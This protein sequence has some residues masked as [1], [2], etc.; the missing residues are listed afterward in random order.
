MMSFSEAIKTC[1]F[2]KIFVTSDTARRSEFWWFVLFCH[3]IE[4]CIFVGLIQVETAGLITMDM[5][6]GIL[7]IS[8]LLLGIP[9]LTAFIRRLHDTG[10]SAWSLLWLFVPYLGWFI[11]LIR[12]LKPGYTYAISR[13]YNDDLDC[14]DYDSAGNRISKPRYEECFDH[15]DE[16]DFDYPTDEEDDYED[17]RR[18]RREEREEYE[19]NYENERRGGEIDRER[20]LYEYCRRMA[21]DAFNEY[22]DYKAKAEDARRDADSR[23]SSAKSHEYYAKEFEDETH[24]R[25][26]EEDYSWAK[27]Y[28]SE[29][30]KYQEESGKY[31]EE[32]QSYKS[33][34]DRHSDNLRR[35]G[36]YV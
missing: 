6:V 33:K 1:L 20:E 8:Y 3:L 28:Y 5:A 7:L 15:N 10:H 30:D 4:T 12:A 13:D 36:V 11:L 35:L 17:E 2:E 31:Y 19:R 21:A 23:L 29:A 24:R 26:A 25:E 14:V 22:E 27:S 32:Y 16:E 18:R 9:L 34:A